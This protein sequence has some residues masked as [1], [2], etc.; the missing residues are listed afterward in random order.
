MA[1]PL[2]DLSNVQKLTYIYYELKSQES[3]RKRAAWYRFLKWIVIIGLV[4]LIATYPT[5]IIG[6]VSEFVRPLIMDQVDAIMEQNK[7]SL[8]KSIKDVLPD[9]IEVA[10]VLTSKATQTKTGS[11]VLPSKPKTKTSPLPKE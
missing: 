1:A 7:N 9:T 4:Y 2:P 11:T 10:P 8:L 5:Q 3:R 6:K